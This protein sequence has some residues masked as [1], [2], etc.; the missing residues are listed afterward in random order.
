MG[1]ED[2]GIGISIFKGLQSSSHFWAEATAPA[3]APPSL[4]SV[5]VSFCAS[6]SPSVFSVSGEKGKNKTRGFL[7]PLDGLKI[8]TNSKTTLFFLFASE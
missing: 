2:Q 5:E 7:Y 6:F 4:F 8:V 3:P 1:K